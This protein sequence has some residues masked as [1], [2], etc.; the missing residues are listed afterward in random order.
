MPNDAAAPPLVFLSHSTDDSAAVRELAR[1]LER[2]GFAVW[3]DVE[4][5]PPAADWLSAIEGALR[6]AD[7]FAVYVGA[8]GIRRWVDR[9]LKAALIRSADDARFRILPILA[10]GAQPEQLPLILRQFQHLDL[11]KGPLAPAALRD[12]LAP[13]LEASAA[14]AFL[15]PPDQAPY[16]GLATFE[17]EDGLL[18]FGRDRE[19]E[20]LLGRVRQQ[21]FVAVLGDSGSGKSSLVRAGLLPALRHIR[22]SGPADTSWRAAVLRPGDDPFRELAN[23]V[24]D[25]VPGADAAERLRLR[26]RATAML[27]G[28]GAG[29]AGGDGLNAC[30]GALVPARM[31]TL[32]VVDQFEELFT[33]T[34]D[35]RSRER[36][37]DTLLAGVAA[38][39][40]RPITV[41]LTM[42]ADFYAQLWFHRPLLARVA[43]SQF[44]VQ[45]PARAELREMI[46]GPLRLAGCHVEAGLTDT[47]LN[48]LGDEPGGLPLLEHALLELWRRRRGNALTHE[49]YGDLGRLRGAIE[50]HAEAIYLAIDPARQSLVQRVLV[51]LTHLAEDPAKDTRRRLPEPVILGLGPDPALAADVV[52]RLATGRLI[53]TGRDAVL[54]T[55]WVELAHEA[56]LQGWSRLRG[57]LDRGRA[58]ELL[59]RR[60]AAD[61]AEWAA[62]RDPDLLYRG[63]RLDS[64]S[65]GAAR[66]S[67][68]LGEPERSFLAA[69]LAA[70]EEEARREDERQGRAKRMNRLVRR[71]AVVLGASSVAL[72]VVSLVAWSAAREARARQHEAESRALSQR[73]LASLDT[74]SVRALMLAV[75]AAREAPTPE[76]VAALR[77]AL[78]APPMRCSLQPLN[79][80]APPE[81]FSRDGR[82]ALTIYDGVS[83]WDT[84]S[85]KRLAVL[86]A[87]RVL[88]AAFSP[89][90]R[91]VVTGGADLQVWDGASGRL[92]ASYEP[93]KK[94]GILSAAFS[95]SGARVIAY[96]AGGTL[97]LWD[98]GTAGALRFAS[99]PNS[100]NDV[101]TALDPSGRT[102]ITLD[103]SGAP[104]LWDA[105]SGR[106][107]DR[108]RSA[109]DVS[110]PRLP[111]PPAKVS[112]PEP[113]DPRR[114]ELRGPARALSNL[115]RS[116]AI[117]RSV[118][119]SPDGRW[120]I[121]SDGS[122]AEALKIWDLS[123]GRLARCLETPRSSIVSHAWSAGGA[124]V[125]TAGG[126][127]SLRL[128]D[129][130]SGREL[131][132]LH[133]SR[134]PIRHVF[135]ASA[136]PTF[137]VLDA[138]GSVSV[139]RHGQGDEPI[140]LASYAEPIVGVALS[141]HGHSLLTRG[142]SH[143]ARLFDVSSALE[144]LALAL[145]APGASRFSNDGRR[146][147]VGCRDGSVHQFAL[148]S[149]QEVVAVTGVSGTFARAQFSGDGSLALTTDT[150]ANN[151][152][153]LWD[154]HG[155]RLLAEFHF[156]GALSAAYLVPGPAI[157]A[158]GDAPGSR[159]AKP[160]VA[161]VIYRWDA[162]GRLTMT[163]NR[164]LPWGVNREGRGIT[165]EPGGRSWITDLA[166]GRDVAEL[167]ATRSP[168]SEDRVFVSDDRELVLTEGAGETLWDGR[169]GRALETFHA[170]D[171]QKLLTADFSADGRY[172]LMVLS[173]MAL[174][175][176]SSAEVWSLAG[177]S[178]KRRVVGSAN[179]GFVF[180]RIAPDGSQFMTY[181]GL[182]SSTASLWD[183]SSG[184]S[185]GAISCPGSGECQPVY[186]PDGRWIVTEPTPTT[187]FVYT[188]RIPDLLRKAETLL[189]VSMTP[190]ER[191]RLLAP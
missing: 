173:A 62:R 174:D 155:A 167:P 52:E 169:T 150:N 82:K 142:F 43:A 177:P 101:T 188:A 64:A 44:P 187:L 103:P 18:F 95:A 180:G 78:A 115:T 160:K 111:A 186:S 183:T 13:I 3:L 102:I 41:L 2:A 87:K 9:E 59:R 56:L 144:P 139:W 85:C 30:V 141:P 61:A 76:A 112:L 72:L 37:V 35:P 25:L 116:V 159:Q 5:L 40:D 21:R 66:L 75:A 51:A 94:H 152:L 48:E 136:A 47:M 73:S 182:V 143:A 123:N 99:A 54:G 153:K 179:V 83:V 68:P 33:L 92:V 16:K 162:R 191:D 32:L 19:V 120:A 117:W 77:G 67:T 158:A 122:Q 23:A 58:A 124:K 189:P 22:Q 161:P 6:E 50:N 135:S 100:T 125:L 28:G 138:A 27:S 106:S 168:Y 148:P 133:P 91:H 97:I 164:Y 129:T 178:L 154:L 131:T 110:C 175:M 184:A 108:S 156:P 104:H 14:S 190:A 105:E 127:G 60:I 172:L 86:A 121:T 17:P 36:F 39:G 11:R 12:R 96:Q 147:L 49:T 15:L 80:I 118:E 4:R 29:G 42:R 145:P 109:G 74:D 8:A 88:T 93:G 24:I 81:G 113:I 53:T 70:R 65:E 146:L 181:G 119:R 69:S 89:D 63:S 45:R 170:K 46:E 151:S 166:L 90:A 38:E 79:Q 20:E 57:W 163:L 98:L 126:D 31:H 132:V 185:L 55:A 128:W 10:P 140:R 71:L 114:L 171:R 7:I 134:L 34:R 157:V 130:A 26:E 84:S 1:Q 137:G 176:R 149:G 107:L 165:R